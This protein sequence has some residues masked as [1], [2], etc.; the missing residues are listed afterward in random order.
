MPLNKNNQTFTI[1]RVIHSPIKSVWVVIGERFGEIEKYHPEVIKSEYAKGYSKGGEG[2]KRITYLNKRKTKMVVEKQ[3]NYD[4]ENF[5]FISKAIQF[6]GAAMSSHDTYMKYRI[7]PI[8]EFSC[9]LIGEMSF[10]TKPAFIG[11]LFKNAMKK[12]K[13]KS[14]YCDR[15]FRNNRRTSKQ[16][17]FINDF[18]TI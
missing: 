13:S 8:D 2:V 18:R 3:I 7:E 16:R 9:T 14:L 10:K 4:P 15:S 11:L 1:S 12:S 6:K 17:K 5:S